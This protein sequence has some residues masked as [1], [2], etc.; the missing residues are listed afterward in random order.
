M[1]QLKKHIVIVYL[2]L[3]NICIGQITG[4]QSYTIN[5]D[6]TTHNF[7]CL[8]K[9]DNGYL[10]AGTNKGLFRF[11]GQNFIPYKYSKK[12]VNKNITALAEDE[13]QV[14]WLGFQNGEIGFLKDNIV[15]LLQVP[16]GHPTVAITS[17]LSDKL[18]TVYFGTA[19]EGIYYYRNNKFASI[20]TDNG[21]SDNYVNDLMINKLGLI[22]ATNKG[23]NIIRLV[24]GKANIKTFSPTN[25]LFDNIVRC[26]YPAGNDDRK[27]IDKNSFKCWFGTEDK[28]FGNFNSY[29]QS[30]NPINI[31]TWIF[32]QINSMVSSGNQVWMA[33]E[34]KGIVIVQFSDSNM[35]RVASIAPSNLAFS[36]AKNLVTDFEGNIWFT[37]KEKLVK[38][39]GVRLQN[40]IPIPQKLFEQ[41]HTIYHDKDHNLWVNTNNGVIKFFYDYEKRGWQSIA[42]NL[43]DINNKSDITCIYQDKFGILWLGTSGKGI[44][45]LDPYSGKT[46]TLSEENLVVNGSILSIIGRDNEVWISSLSGVVRCSLYADN[47]DIFNPYYLVKFT[48]ANNIGSNHIYTIFIDSKNRVWFATDGRGITVYENKKFTIYNK[49]N[50]LKSLVFY[51]I[52]ED[53]NGSIWFSTFNDGL[54]KFDGVSF[55][56]LSTLDGLSEPTTTSLIV[57]DKNNI[58]ALGNRAINIIDATTLHVAYFDNTQGFGQIN[59]DLNCI[60]GKHELYLVS[61][62]GI[63]QYTPT[64]NSLVPKTILNHVQLFLSD[65]GNTKKRGFS[66]DENNFS[67]SYTGIS[68]SHPD[69]IRYQYKLEGLAY[70]WSTTKDDNIN[71]PKLSPG[72]Y[73]FR[74]RSSIN[75]RFENSNEASF[76]FTIEKP[77]WLQWWFIAIAAFIAAGLL[78]M[79]IKLREKGVQ[80]WDRIE[81]EKIQSQFEVL[82]SQINP[83]FLFNSFN[84]LISVIEDNPENAVQYVE[85][86]SDLYRKIVTYRDKD[87]ITLQEEIDIINDYFFIQ[88][89][90]FGDSLMFDNHIVDDDQKKYMI[91]SLTLQLLTENAVKHN[92][93]SAETSLVIELFIEGSFLVVRNNINPKIAPEKG[94]GMGL[95][96]IQKRYKLISKADIQINKTAD[97]FIVKIPLINS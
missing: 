78:Y 31:D 37:S 42:I 8:R 62:K 94:A 74:V 6:N 82:K 77:F 30:M 85:H 20:K 97:F 43:R 33:T 57:D 88:K 2:L 67:F 90:R 25:G 84:T 60:T 12:V 27:I 83:H 80:R 76:A 23:I 50:G 13:N 44:I 22:A 72:N 75:N 41:I 68:Y 29:S 73:T 10:M 93:I 18:G 65:I 53:K 69:K 34:K 21:L 32:G 56:H 49:S 15:D 40:I 48:E 19:G 58:I 39:N 71:F 95:Q 54:Y 16:E 64:G 35:N 51:S 28:G 4:I 61:N 87:F 46:R 70:T 81:K 92:A 24:N 89:K 1:F 11:D 7:Y 36:N 38:T 14:V 59:S 45:L 66:Y 3:G 52:C 26:L 55:T 17:I 63:L 96:N 91:A 5:T 9:L 86:L 79:Y 47:Y